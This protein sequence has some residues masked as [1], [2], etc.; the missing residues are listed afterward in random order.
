MHCGLY[1]GGGI[2]KG[3]VIG[4]TDDL[5][6]KIVDF[7]WSGKRAIYMEDVACTIYSAMGIDWTKT[8]ESTPSGRAF[9]YVEPAS[10]TR[11][12][13]FQPVQEFFA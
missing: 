7:G 9:H 12:M 1:A 13:D 2:R 6:G 10:G 8:I 3:A 5:G 4:K 11:Y